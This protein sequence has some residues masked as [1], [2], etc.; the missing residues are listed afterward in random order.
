MKTTAGETQ[1]KGNT[2]SI[3]ETSVNPSRN[4]PAEKAAPAKAAITN[5]A[6][7]DDH[8]KPPSGRELVQTEV[9]SPVGVLQLIASATGIRALLWP[10]DGARVRVGETQRVDAAAHPVLL[11]A[12]EQLEHYFAGTLIEFELPLDPL[13]TP[14]QLEAWEALSRIPYGKTAS[15]AEQATKIGRPK[16]V[17]AVGA[18]N[19]KNPISIIVPCHRVIGSNG[20]LTGFAAGVEAKRWLL[21]HE[22]RVTGK[23]LF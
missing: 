15:Y 17:R 12:K 4:P 5:A 1:S 19:G 10:T 18:A 16:A 11:A 23:S 21:E 7:P 8:L 13:G 2:M 6:N 9:Q 22:R 3:T 14:F 20:S